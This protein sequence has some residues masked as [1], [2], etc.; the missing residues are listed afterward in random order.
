MW[1]QN[2]VCEVLTNK[3]WFTTFIWMKKIAGHLHLICIKLKVL[4]LSATIKV[5][6]NPAQIF[7]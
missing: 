3:T 4:R 2:L 5:T 1:C 7:L 6:A